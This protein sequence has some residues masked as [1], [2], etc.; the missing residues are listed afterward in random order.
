L[1]VEKREIMN[2]DNMGFVKF[3]EFNRA[4][5]AIHEQHKDRKIAELYPEIISWRASQK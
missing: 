3:R 4:L 5:I 2:A 1:V